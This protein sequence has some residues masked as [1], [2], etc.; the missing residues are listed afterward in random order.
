MKQLHS[1]KKRVERDP[2]SLGETVL[3]M[4]QRSVESGL[5]PGPRTRGFL[6][7]LPMVSRSRL[8]CGPLTTALRAGTELH[9]GRARLGVLG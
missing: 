7:G 1:S 8:D 3:L 9:T 6:S 4:L 5:G 2:D